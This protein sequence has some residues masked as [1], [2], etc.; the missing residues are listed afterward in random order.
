MK[1]THLEDVHLGFYYLA[2]NKLITDKTQKIFHL[3]MEHSSF[4]RYLIIQI[5]GIIFFLAMKRKIWNNLML[6]KILWNNPMLRKILW[7]D[8]VICIP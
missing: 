6:R 1:I 5:N 4:I 3:I 7:N 2:I 8:F